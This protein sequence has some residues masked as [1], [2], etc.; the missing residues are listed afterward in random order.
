M[1]LS[2]TSYPP[3]AT[4][5]APA[6]EWEPLGIV[7][8]KLLTVLFFV[9]LNGFFVACEF[10]IVKVRGSELQ[11]L[12]ERGTSRAQ[13][14][15]HVAAHLDAYLSATQ[16]G[17]TLASLALGWLGEPFLARML[18][19]FFV[20][21][22]VGSPAV[23]HAVSFALAFA[24]ITFLHIVIGELTPKSLAIRRA[25]QT[26]LWVSRPLGFF[27][28]LFK[29][30][31]SLLNGAANFILRHA[32]RIDPVAE[33]ERA[34]SEEE[35]RVILAESH[36]AEEV[37]TL[38]KEMLLNVLDLRR[39]TARDI[40]TPRQR[41]VFLDLEDALA[42]NLRVA[43][44][45]G[46]TRFPLARGHLDQA[47]GLIHVK[48][49][50]ALADQPGRD[51]L[52]IKRDLLTVP[53]MLSLPRL[54]DLFLSRHVHMALV[55]DEFGGATGI[56]TLD[57]VLE[58]LV[59][60]IQDEFDREPPAIE[61]L[62]ADEFIVRGRLPLHELRGQTG[63]EVACEEV[64]T[65]GGYIIHL[66]GRLPQ[67]GETVQIGGYRAAVTK[68]DSRRV[69]RIKFQRAPAAAELPADARCRK[70]R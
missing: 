45:S 2:A 53:E 54:L 66:L 68:C 22:G 64:S 47:L 32:L 20:L 34:H 8:L 17:I 40:V 56:V 61:H 52:A 36:R 28:T 4:A 41:V 39:L 24:A 14:A 7:L 55:L 12:V 65:V 29:P 62:S 9:L 69:R 23:V 5:L 26:T 44:A 60:E 3:I 27:Y 1:S 11:S 37:S 38:E 18:E 46:H 57:N 21:A 48:D 59:G 10:A 67:E 33:T 43:R 50:L 25:V 49:L 42:E 19:P 31:I 70:G 51:L 58:E 16:L 6:A 35:L 15:R 13:F 30:A 63:L